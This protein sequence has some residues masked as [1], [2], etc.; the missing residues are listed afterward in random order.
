MPDAQREQR[1]GRA[2]H[3]RTGDRPH[4]GDLGQ[5]AQVQHLRIHLDLVERVGEVVAE[6]RSRQDAGVQFA[7]LP[8]GGTVARTADHVRD[9]PAVDDQGGQRVDPAGLRDRGHEKDGLGPLVDMGLRLRETAV[10]L[11]PDDAAELRK[12]VITIQ[13]RKQFAAVRRD[14]LRRQVA[15]V[16]GER[17]GETLQF[18]AQLRRV[19]RRILHGEFRER[20]GQQDAAGR[21]DQ[22]PD[23]QGQQQAVEDPGEHGRRPGEFVADRDHVAGQQDQDDQ[24]QRRTERDQRLFHMMMSL[25]CRSSDSSVSSRR[26]SSGLIIGSRQAEKRS[27]ICAR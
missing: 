14:L 2:V 23:Q 5:G 15:K 13:L 20:P 17:A 3:Q 24:G 21:D 10:Q 26:S 22:Q 12:V 7:E 16:V 8:P 19:L 25:S 6:Q 18:G 4:E 1:V 9:H 27:R 11:R